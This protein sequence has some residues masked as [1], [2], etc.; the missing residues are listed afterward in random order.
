MQTRHTANTL[1]WTTNNG[2]T[3]TVEAMGRGTY[4]VT[5]DG[6]E[7]GNG[8]LNDNPKAIPD[9]AYRAGVRA[10]IFAGKPVALTAERRDALLT[11]DAQMR[12]HLRAETA[13]RDELERLIDAVR[14]AEEALSTHGYGD[15]GARGRVA[16]DAE[17]AL[18]L[19]TAA[20]PA[21]V[22][23]Y[24][25]EWQA[26]RDARQAEMSAAVARALRGED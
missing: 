6:K 18:R 25:A 2:Q 26:E 4:T 15:T 17:T 5:L 22:A 19:W 10:I 7:T 12:A 23:A 8:P 20:H 1:T 14:A 11:L 13:E 9:A 21:T 24:R 3:V 16:E